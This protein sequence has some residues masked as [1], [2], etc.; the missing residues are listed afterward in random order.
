VLTHNRERKRYVVESRRLITAR[1]LAAGEACGVF[2]L[3]D[4]D[5]PELETIWSLAQLGCNHNPQEVNGLCER[6]GGW[7]GRC[8]CVVQ[9]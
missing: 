7:H 5:F 8:I 9:L 6:R 4:S 1:G 2:H 3:R